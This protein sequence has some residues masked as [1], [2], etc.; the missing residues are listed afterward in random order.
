M[1]NLKKKE[2]FT[3][4]TYPGSD[5][6][7][8]QPIKTEVTKS[9][10]YLEFSFVSLSHAH[11]FISFYMVILIKETFIIKFD[12]EHIN[13]TTTYSVINVKQQLTIILYSGSGWCKKLTESCTLGYKFEIR[14]ND[15]V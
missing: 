5:V 11:Y 7:L 14:H 9:S 12:N 8:S 15:R 1:K 10:R 3:T 4:Y 13:A 6:I 2:I